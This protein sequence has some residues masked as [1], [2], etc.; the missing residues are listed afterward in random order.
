MGGVRGATGNF[1]SLTYLLF[2]L[3]RDN[4]YSFSQDFYLL[5]HSGEVSSSLSH[6]PGKMGEGVFHVVIWRNYLSSL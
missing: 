4:S 1:L 6:H 5:L 2:P 3:N